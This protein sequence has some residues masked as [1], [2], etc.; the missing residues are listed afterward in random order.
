MLTPVNHKQWERPVWA[1][2]VMDPYTS[3]NETER[4]ALHLGFWA[5]MPMSLPLQPQAAIYSRRFLGAPSLRPREHSIVELIG[6]GYSN[7][8]IG[9]ELGITPET[10][11]SHLKT[12][13]RK[14]EVRKRAQAVTRAQELGY[15]RLS[16]GH[17]SPTTPDDE[18]RT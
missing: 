14:L 10:V 6:R 9:R 18:A 7:N 1:S 17:Q 11:K 4:A 2:R 13:F 3:L 16:G 12:L 15:L 5:A 8:A